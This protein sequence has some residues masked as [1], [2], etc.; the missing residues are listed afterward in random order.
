MQLDSSSES[1]SLF[2][3]PKLTHKT[4]FSH[5]DCTSVGFFFLTTFNYGNNM[6][7][8]AFEVKVL[9]IWRALFGLTSIIC[10]PIILPTLSKCWVVNSEVVGLAF[11]FFFFLFIGYITLILLVI[12]TPKIASWPNKV[13]W[14]VSE[15]LKSWP[16]ERLG[17]V[18]GAHQ[19]CALCYRYS[20]FLPR[21]QTPWAILMSTTIFTPL[22]RCEPCL[23]RD[24]ERE[25]CQ[26]NQN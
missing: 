24:V 3:H 22:R 23:A 2:F 7:E 16:F 19:Q 5:T 21:T 12:F 20:L 6:E 11:L 9:D 26:E 4:K 8:L 17:L 13:D 14:L 1:N 15:L 25:M 18:L 10:H